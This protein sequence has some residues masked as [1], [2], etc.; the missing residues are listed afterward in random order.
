MSHTSK[1]RKILSSINWINKLGIKKL[2]SV[3]IPEIPLVWS[4]FNNTDDE[5]VRLPVLEKE[6]KVSAC[7]F[8]AK[9]GRIFEAHFHENNSETILVREGTITVITPEYTKVL[10]KNETLT[11]RKG[12][13]HICHF[14]NDNL[15]YCLIEITWCPPMNG[16]EGAFIL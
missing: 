8:K 13:P 6:L 14:K 9:A 4:S 10:N 7:L 5:W 3:V 16:W 2:K 15:D 11:I 12:L 1:V